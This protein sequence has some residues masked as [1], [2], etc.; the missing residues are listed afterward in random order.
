MPSDTAYHGDLGDHFVQLSAVH[1][2]NAFVD[3][4]AML[5]LI[6]DVAGLDVVDVGCG[7]GFYSA[8]MI[9]RGARVTGVEGSERLLAHAEEATR[10]RATLVQHDLEQP[11]PFADASFDLAVMALVYHHVYDRKQLLSEL[12]RVLR[13]GARLLASGTHAAGEQRWLG[14]SYYEGGRVDAPVGDG[15]TINFERMTIERFVNELIDGGFV[16]E[17]L[18]EPRPSEELREADPAEYER[19]SDRPSVLTLALRRPVD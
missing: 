9:E 5:A 15:L 1:P 14:G 6:G 11:L 3:R 19:I 4:P 16:L 12:R 7:A 17:R 13:P 2:T 18:L 10:G 8:A